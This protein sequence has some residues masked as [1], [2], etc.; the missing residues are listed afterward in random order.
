MQWE[1]AT[2]DGEFADPPAAG[3]PPEPV[4]DGLPLHAAAKRARAAVAMTAAAVRAVGGRARHGLRMTRVL[5]FIMP[6]SRGCIGA[7]GTAPVHSRAQPM[8]GA[9]Q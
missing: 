4:D 8:T 5:S 7:G 2:A 9:E 3:E 1:K 6:S